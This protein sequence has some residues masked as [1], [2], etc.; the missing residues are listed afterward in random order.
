MMWG[1]FLDK[2]SANEMFLYFV[3]ITKISARWLGVPYIINNTKC[4]HLD[5]HVFPQDTHLDLF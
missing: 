3:E 1:E 4:T 5:I 2:L